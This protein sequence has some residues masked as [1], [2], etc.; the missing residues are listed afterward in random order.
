[1]WE[2]SKV[3]PALFHNFLINKTNQSSLSNAYICTMSN[4]W[5]EGKKV[6]SVSSMHLLLNI[7]HL[8]SPNEPND[9]IFHASL[10]ILGSGE[11]K[12]LW[13]AREL[14]GE[15]NW[16]RNDVDSNA[17]L[18]KTVG[19]NGF[20]LPSK[21]DERWFSVQPPLPQVH[22]GVTAGN[23]CWGLWGRSYLARPW[24]PLPLDT[25]SFKDCFDP[26][27]GNDTWVSIHHNAEQ[28]QSQHRHA[29]CS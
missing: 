18:R 10:K 20:S 22:W 27:E 24:E 19:R 26:P 4:T 13:M 21:S 15:A 2:L 14:H 9:W 28:M 6:P 8:E 16:G 25:E 7:R 29:H 5:V 3:S 1:M 17:L 12:C 23:R 11:V